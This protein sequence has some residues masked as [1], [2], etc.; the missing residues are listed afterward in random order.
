MK[1]FKVHLFEARGSGNEINFSGGLFLDRM[2][3][4]SRSR[5]PIYT[6]ANNYSNSAHLLP[7]TPQ[8]PQDRGDSDYSSDYR[9]TESQ[10]PLL[11]SKVI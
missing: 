9:M 5:T 2:Q 1:I 3:V 6:D 7:V 8:L 11:S 10:E 4:I